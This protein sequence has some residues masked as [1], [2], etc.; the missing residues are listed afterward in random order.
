MG[1]CCS[2]D[3]GMSDLP[4]A[5]CCSRLCA[6]VGGEEQAFDLSDHDSNYQQPSHDLGA[7]SWQIWF[8]E[9]KTKSNLDFYFYWRKEDSVKTSWVKNPILK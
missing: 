4:R 8:E 2:K 1:G 5:G 9:N 3:D 7:K 6:K